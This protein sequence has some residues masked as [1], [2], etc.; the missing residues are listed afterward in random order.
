MSALTLG[1]AT[2]IARRLLNLNA[3]L[4]VKTFVNYLSSVKLYNQSERRGA[5]PGSNSDFLDTI[6]EPPRDSIRR[7]MIRTICDVASNK[8]YQRW[9]ILAHSQ[10]S[11]VA[12]NGLME[13]GS[14]WIGYLDEARLKTLRNEHMVRNGPLDKCPLTPARPLWSHDGE[15]VDRTRIFD[16]FAGML[17]YGSPLEKFAA[18]WPGRVPVFQEA[19]FAPHTR[20]INAFDPLDAVSGV[21]H[22]W[23]DIPS[24]FCPVVENIGYKSSP[25]LLL[26]HIKYLDC[27]P[28]SPK[29]TYGKRLADRVSCWLLNPARF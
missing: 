11:V 5:G 20:W 8:T 7:R 27:P 17:T 13:P 23:D 25:I 24:A 19:A 15:A 2:V 28:A 1:L 9:Y 10:G 29:D 6:G 16:R 4:F 18:I 3:F 22:T 21:I 26:G 12:F 14:G